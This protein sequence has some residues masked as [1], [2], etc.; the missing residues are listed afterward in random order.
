MDLVSAIVGLDQ[1]QAMSSVQIAVA[2][3]MLD[4]D[5]STGNAA[6]Q[7][8]Q[9]ADNEVNGAGDALVAAATGLGGSIDTYA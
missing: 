6:V 4:V 7:L 3:K 9:S 8:I 1:A 2:K 5:R